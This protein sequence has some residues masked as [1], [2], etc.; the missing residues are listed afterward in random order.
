[1]NAVTRSAALLAL[2]A[3]CGQDP[4]PPP[5]PLPVSALSAGPVEWNAKKLAV[6]T[7]AAVAELGDDTLVLSSQGALVFTGGVLLSSDATVRAWRQAAVI[8]A[9]DLSGDW[10]AGVDGAGAVRRLRDR[11]AMESVSDRYGLKGVK[12]RD[13]VSL[14]AGRVAFALEPAGLAVADG[15]RVLRYDGD[16]AGLAGGGGKAASLVEGGV[17]VLDP[18]SGAARTYPLPGAAALAFDASGKLLAAAGSALYAEDGDALRS[19]YE[20]GAPITA[21]AAAGASV[22]LAVGDTLAIVDEAGLRRGAPGLLPAGAAL[23]GS[24][25]GDV[26][27][28]ASGKLLRYAE[29]SAAGEDEEQWKKTV[30]PV[31]SRL[32]SLCHLPRGSSGIDLSTYKAWASRRALMTQR[33][34]Q[35][36][37]TPMPPAGAGALTAAERDALTAW[38]SKQ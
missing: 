19:I 28:L 4:P 36:K 8:P 25:S 34:L 1:M 13:V 11:S 20:A 30:L 24:P 23:R 5:E 18:A 9:G 15:E 38:L 14:G 6:G 17:R 2:L 29:A 16:Y 7:V 3:A 10:M 27:A 21:L 26:W 37:P 22:W 31:F 32:C 12:V 35:G 33:V